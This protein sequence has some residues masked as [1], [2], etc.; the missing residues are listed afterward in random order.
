MV[1][2]YLGSMANVVASSVGLVALLVCVLTNRGWF[3]FPIVLGVYGLVAAV[4]W[5]VLP[6][7]P[8]PQPQPPVRPRRAA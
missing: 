6:S 8:E 4:A 3:T 2:R 1:M 7:R 5:L